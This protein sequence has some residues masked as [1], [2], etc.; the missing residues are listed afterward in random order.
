MTSV[1]TPDFFFFH[2][3]PRKSWSTEE[4]VMQIQ[5]GDKT[6]KT[7][8]NNNKL[9][10]REARKNAFQDNIITLQKILSHILHEKF[11]KLFL[12]K[13]LQIYC[14]NMQH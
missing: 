6:C 5:R 3:S 1:S 11:L 13:T 12:E 2:S 14:L 7:M 4:R 9:I 10:K 8:Y